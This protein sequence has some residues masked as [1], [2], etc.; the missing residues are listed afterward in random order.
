MH[1][2]SYLQ[3]NLSLPNESRLQVIRSHFISL[4]IMPLTLNLIVSEMESLKLNNIPRIPI[5]IIECLVVGNYKLD[6]F[7]GVLDV[8]CRCLPS[9]MVTTLLPIDYDFINHLNLKHKP[10]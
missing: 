5:I 7:F 3:T 9:I 10:D 4:L 1:G 6:S 2:I 8:Y